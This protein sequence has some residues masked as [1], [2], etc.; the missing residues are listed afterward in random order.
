MRLVD[1]WMGRDIDYA[2]D[3]TDTIRA[4]AAITVNRANLLLHEFGESRN[5]NSGWRPPSINAATPGAAKKSLHMTG[6]AVDISDDDGTLDEWCMNN[7]ATLA[8]IGLWLEHPSST[9]RWC[10]LQT[11]APKSGN[12]VFF[13]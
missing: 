5:V 12:R 7:Q 3:M 4:N 6:E 13:P 2:S 1:Y 8:R 9:P 10:H 11:V